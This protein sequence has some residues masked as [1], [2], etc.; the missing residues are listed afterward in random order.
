[1]RNADA[2]RGLLTN[3]KESRWS[4]RLDRE[5][6]NRSAIIVSTSTLSGISE[7]SPTLH[8]NHDH[9]NAPCDLISRASC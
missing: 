5:L 1:M 2:K 7:P 4:A 3:L 6:P 8:L 9:R